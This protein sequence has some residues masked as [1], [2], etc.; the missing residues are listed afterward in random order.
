MLPPGNFRNLRAGVALQLARFP[1]SIQNRLYDIANRAFDSARPVAK[2]AT[3][4][5][6]A[7]ALATATAS[8]QRRI[9]ATP[10]LRIHRER[11]ILV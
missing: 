4:F 5:T 9:R 2:S 6:S 1:L 11:R 10:K 3:R 7:A 8:P